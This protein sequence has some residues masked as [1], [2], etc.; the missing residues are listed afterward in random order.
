[1][2]ATYEPIATT[3]LTGAVATI[4]F[5]S[6]PNTYTDLRLVLGIR[7]MTASTTSFYVILNNDSATNYSYT[8]LGGNGNTATSNR[9]TTTNLFLNGTYTLS[10]TQP[11]LSTIDIFSYAGSTYK[12]LLS[13]LSADQNGTGGFQCNTVGMW[14]NTAAITRVDFKTTSTFAANTVAT[15]YGILK[16]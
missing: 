14:R 11:A 1:M 13:S 2:P 16:A 4:T 15:L 8:F 9:G 12:T 5:N 3:T 7:N 10:A 6:I